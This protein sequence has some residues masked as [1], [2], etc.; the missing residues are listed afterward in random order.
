MQAPKTPVT[1]TAAVAREFAL[2]AVAA[3][4]YVG[5]RAATEG[6]VATAVANGHRIL[7][8]EHRL[9]LAW[10]DAA[11][12]ALLD[13]NV[14]VTLANWI[15]IWGHWPVIVA[16]GVVL[17]LRRRDAYLLLRRAMLI[18]GGLGFLFFALLP[19][20]PP[21]LLPVGLVDTVVERSGSYRALQP[22]ELTNQY[23]AMPSL[24]FG[25]NL[26]VGIVLFLTFTT[27]AVRV[28]AV[29]MPAAMGFAVVATANHYV[30]DV[31]AGGALVLLALAVSLAWNAATLQPHAGAP[32]RHRPPRRERSRRASAGR[33]ARA[34]LGGG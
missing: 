26:L 21:R 28:F 23:A 16:C 30:L 5:V 33:D 2:V 25:W 3:A 8:L 34:S 19:V 18:S 29:V 32:L 11:Q 10:E 14:L 6:S 15:Y 17:F 31:V 20:A 27:L 13:A 24:H 7:D 22:P 4:A 9:G 12:D 1:T